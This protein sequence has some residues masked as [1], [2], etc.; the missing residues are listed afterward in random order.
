[1]FAFIITSVKFQ[2][3][4]LLLL[5]PKHEFL[6]NLHG[7][8]TPDHKQQAGSY[9]LEQAGSMFQTWPPDHMQQAGSYT[10]EQS[11]SLFQ[12]WP[13]DNMML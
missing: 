7:V 6:P 1:M 8:Y 4:L 12:T 11:G 3:T 10:L 2:L 9:T 5:L 13:P